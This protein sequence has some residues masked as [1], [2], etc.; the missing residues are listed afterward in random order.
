MMNYQTNFSVAYEICN[1]ESYHPEDDH[2]PL[3]IP[4]WGHPG[5]GSV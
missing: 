3:P 4:K 2:T 1:I 5:W